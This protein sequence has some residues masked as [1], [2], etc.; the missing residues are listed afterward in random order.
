MPG[1][2]H[3]EALHPSISFTTR[4]VSVALSK[5][6]WSPKENIVVSGY[7]V[8]GTVRTTDASPVAGATVELVAASIIA[9][10]TSDANGRFVFDNAPFGKYAVRAHLA[11]GKQ[12]TFTMLPESLPVDL[13]KHAN[14]V[15][16]D[17]F[18]L[19][20]VSIV[21]S[22]AHGASSLSAGKFSIFLS[23]AVAIMLNVSPICLQSKMSVMVKFKGT[24]LSFRFKLIRKLGEFPRNLCMSSMA[25]DMKLLLPSCC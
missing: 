1:D 25:L 17:S 8:E 19:S 15:L 14:V 21:S 10:T 5:E 20:S 11:V 6:N 4:R 2:Y 13:S 9:T 3:V 23:I 22:I 7:R 16:A 24:W 18:V 12:L